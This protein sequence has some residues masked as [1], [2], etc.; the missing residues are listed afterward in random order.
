MGSAVEAL[1]SVSGA[2]PVKPPASRVAKPA[3]G[4]YIPKVSDYCE[5]PM[6]IR[7]LIVLPALC[8]LALGNA[9]RADDSSA[10]AAS[11]GNT[12]AGKQQN[13]LPTPVPDVPK[14]KPGA[15]P[16]NQPPTGP[17]PAK[18]APAPA[19]K[20]APPPNQG[21]VT[22]YGPGGLGT[23]PGAPANPPYGFGGTGAPR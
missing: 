19:G 6:R 8:G 15:Y 7:W 20:F 3:E 14:V 10:P 21:P 2:E 17:N 1:A 18:S 23:P 5:P 22:G 4:T 16:Y 9:A 11:G 13:V 12:S